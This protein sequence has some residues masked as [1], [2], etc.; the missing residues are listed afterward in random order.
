MVSIVTI[1]YNGWQDTCEM[2][3]SL[4]RYE[5]CPYEVIVVDN[6]S[7]GDDIKHI[8]ASFPDVTIIR[9]EKNLGFAGG[10]NLG[11]K[12]AKGEYIFFLNNDVVIQA[13]VLEV[14]IK[15]LLRPH[16]GGVSPMIRYYDPPHKIQYFGYQKM[17]HI[18]LKHT[19]PPFDT[20]HP[21]KYFIDGE[22]DVMHGAAMMLSRK[23]IEQVGVMAECYFLYYE[24]FDWSHRLLE[25]GYRIWYEPSALIFHKEGTKKGNELIPFREFYLVRGRILFARR[26]LVGIDKFLSCCYL[27][28]GVMPRNVLKYLLKGRWKSISAVFC[29]SFSGLFSRK[30]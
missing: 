21:E 5:T 17:S 6:A 2:I 1:N 13:P 8:A 7:R 11:Y 26:N 9:S 18:T 16:I 27:L 3:A 20:I 30:V 4:K 25:Q 15:H 28:G 19:T 29:G 14:L 23:V 22:T 10:N 24:E 12:W